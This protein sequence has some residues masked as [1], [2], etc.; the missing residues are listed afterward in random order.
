MGEQYEDFLSREILR[1]SDINYSLRTENQRLKVCL[2]YAGL[3][4]FC[5]K[6]LKDKEDAKNKDMHK[7]TRS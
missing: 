6:K 1:L 2:K 4:A 7:R 5:L 3:Y